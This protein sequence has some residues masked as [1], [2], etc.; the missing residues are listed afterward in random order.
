MD[1]HMDRPLARAGQGEEYL[2]QLLLKFFLGKTCLGQG[3]KSTNILLSRKRGK[4]HSIYVRTVSSQRLNVCITEMV[5]TIQFNPKEL[6]LFGQSNQYAICL[7][8]DALLSYIYTVEKDKRKSLEKSE[9]EEKRT[10]NR[11]SIVLTK[12]R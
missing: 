12:I 10:P 9:I 3:D 11:K 1:D 2:I 6:G 7:Q 5:L 8:I 4:R